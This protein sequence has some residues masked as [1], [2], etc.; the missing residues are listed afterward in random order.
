MKRI[1]T[2]LALCVGG[3]VVADD[4]KAQSF[5][6]YS[7][8]VGGDGGRLTIGVGSPGYG[9]GGYGY[10]RPAYGYA[11]PY[12]VPSYGYGYSPYVYPSYGYSNFYSRPSYGYGYGGRGYRNW[13]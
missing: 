6:R 8:R 13:R 12:V 10:G 7:T 1:L 2:V 5:L 9:Y 3:L 4:A 11:S